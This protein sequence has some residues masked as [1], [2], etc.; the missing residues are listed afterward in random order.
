MKRNI[1]SVKIDQ[2]HQMAP[3]HTIIFPTTYVA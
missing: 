3:P 1:T 2:V